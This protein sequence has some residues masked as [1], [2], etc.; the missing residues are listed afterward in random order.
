MAG[1]IKVGVVCQVNR[2]G[3]IGCR[4]VF[5]AQGI[6]VRQHIGDG[7]RQRTGIPLLAIGARVGQAQRLTACSFDDGS[8]PHYLV[9]AL[10]SAVQMI[11]PVV[12]CYAI[13]LAVQLKASSG[14]AV[15]HAACYAAEIGALLLVLLERFKPQHDIAQFTVAIGNQ[16]LGENTTVGNHAGLRALR[17][18][19]RIAVDRPSVGRRTKRSSLHLCLHLTCHCGDHRQCTD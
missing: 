16:Q 17:I 14:N 2:R 13:G 19:H 5:D 10:D 11:G 3:A 7:N 8:V 12:N 18:G 9:E 6:V 1:Q 4:L 15:G